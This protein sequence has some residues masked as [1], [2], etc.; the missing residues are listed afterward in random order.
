MMRSLWTAAA[1]MTTQQLSVDTI[2]NNIA[3]VNTT[4]YKKERTEFQ[5]LL[6]QTMERASLDAADTGKPVNLQV[7]LGVKPVAM[8]K[9]FTTGSLQETGNL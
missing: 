4:G 1:G 2:S 3:N 8:T 6:Y 5:T 7:G 9:N